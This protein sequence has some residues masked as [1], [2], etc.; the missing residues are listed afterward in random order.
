MSEIDEKVREV[1]STPALPG[2]RLELNGKLTRPPLEPNLGTESLLRLAF[3][4][5]TELDMN[6]NAI[7]EYG[8]SDGCFTSSLGVATL[9][10]LGPLTM[11]MCG[12]EERIEISSLTPRAALLAG[13]IH[14]LPA[15]DEPRS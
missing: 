9:D 3:E 11:D 1:A 5:A 6:L 10:G 14:R 8:G 15:V 13:I 4:T 7:E 2:V 12:D